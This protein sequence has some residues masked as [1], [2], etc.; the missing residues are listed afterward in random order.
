MPGKLRQRNRGGEGLAR[1]AGGSSSLP[2][3]ET[4]AYEAGFRGA[5]HLQAEL[6]AQGYL[7]APVL[8]QWGLVANALAR[9]AKESPDK[10]QPIL[11]LY[12]HPEGRIRFFAPATLS[13]VMPDSPHSVLELLRPLAADRDRRVAEAVQAFGIRPQAEILGAEVV[14]CLFPWV[15]DPSPFVRR[16][17]ME[18]TRPRGIW[19][20]H[21]RWAVENPASLV[22][23]LDE[24]RFED[25]RFVA[26]ALGNAMNDISKSHPHLVL[27]L[28][29]RWIAEERTGEL[30]GH[31]LKKGTRGLIKEGHP[32]A[33][34]L[35]GLKEL[36]VEANAIVL[37][38]L[39]ARPNKKVQFQIELKNLG[40]SG[41]GKLVY[42]IQTPG[43]VDGR[44]RRKRYHGKTIELPE[45]IP[46]TAQCHERLFDTQAA[47]LIDGACRILIFLNG[48][49][50][51]EVPFELVR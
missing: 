43:K 40:E 22:P 20:K 4:A 24:L 3:L 51:A 10:I 37:S 31:I 14:S 49:N 34:H 13:L 47:P 27:D 44:P 45:S 6:E 42:E 23:L 8:E 30:L 15:Q 7:E 50:V 21:L 19:V 5:W 9:H 12:K 18:G 28:F 33:L 29:R 2:L 26:N 46:V 17:A 39:P 35:F 16:A 1:E 36:R 32:G 25:H 48:K 11:N 41:S 38:D